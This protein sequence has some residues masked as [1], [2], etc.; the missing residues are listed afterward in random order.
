MISNK[1]DNHEIG[2]GNAGR[3]VMANGQL[4]SAA[5]RGSQRWTEES[6]SHPQLGGQCVHRV[7]SAP[8]LVQGGPASWRRCGSPSGLDQAG[9]GSSLSRNHFG[10]CSVSVLSSTKSSS[11]PWEPFSHVG[12]SLTFSRFLFIKLKRKIPR[13]CNACPC[14]EFYQY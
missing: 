5:I 11:S 12:V 6:V 1:Q 3:G 9:E 10:L 14:F 2:R 7:C 13:I 4:K 8:W